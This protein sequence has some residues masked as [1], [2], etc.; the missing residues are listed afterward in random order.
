MTTLTPPGV[1]TIIISNSFVRIS[2]GLRV[3]IFAVGSEPHFRMFHFYSLK[4]SLK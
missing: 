4:K 1:R 3:Y 2:A